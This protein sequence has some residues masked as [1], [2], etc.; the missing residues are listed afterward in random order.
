MARTSSLSRHNCPW[1]V[2]LLFLLLIITEAKRAAPFY[3]GWAKRS[4][5]SSQ[6]SSTSHPQE[7]CPPPTLTHTLADR[8]IT[9]IHISSTIATVTE[10]QTKALHK[11]AK[12]GKHHHHR[13]HTRHGDHTRKPHHAQKTR[14]AN[15][16]A[17]HSTPAPAHQ[18]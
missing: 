13:T 6:V 2:L 7:S 3:L 14:Y 5:A 4:A 17:A 1:P 11:G 8:R 15:D 9:T 18:A 16:A 12:T 10:T